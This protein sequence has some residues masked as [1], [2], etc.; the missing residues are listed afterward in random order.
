MSDPAGQEHG[1]A[2][3][4]RLR[5][6]EEDVAGVR[7]MISLLALAVA[8]AVWLSPWREYPVLPYLFLPIGVLA[9]WSIAFE[10]LR[11]RRSASG[12][13]LRS[14][15]PAADRESENSPS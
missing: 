1:D 11:A 7:F 8:I 5:H 10:F 13:N 12:R 15:A 3:D 6:L 14:P 2:G 9:F 4:G